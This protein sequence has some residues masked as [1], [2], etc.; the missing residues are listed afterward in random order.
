MD[1]GVDPP[2]E[3][4]FLDFFYEQPFPSDAGERDVEDHVA[5]RPDLRDLD[6]PA[7]FPLDLELDELGLPQGELAAAASETD[8][9]IRVAQSTLLP[10]S[11]ALFR[12]GLPGIFFFPHPG[13]L[14]GIRA[15]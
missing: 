11:C 12:R 15:G 2:G 4:R 5:R 13:L 14:R 8:Q 9:R 7:R 10:V 1:R 6:L 3:Q